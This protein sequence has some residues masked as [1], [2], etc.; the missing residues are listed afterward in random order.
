MIPFA[1]LQQ[2]WDVFLMQFVLILNFRSGR[3]LASS[4]LL[5]PLYLFLLLV[6][7]PHIRLADGTQISLHRR[8]PWTQ[9]SLR[10]SCSISFLVWGPPDGG[11]E[12]TGFLFLCVAPRTPLMSS[13]A[14]SAPIR[15]LLLRPPCCLPPAPST[16][17]MQSGTCGRRDM[18][19]FGRIRPWQRAPG[20]GSMARSGPDPVAIG[21]MERTKGGDVRIQCWNS[22]TFGVLFAGFN[23]SSD[24]HSSPR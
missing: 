17:A 14:L 4:L 6:C 7:R 5:A 1:I 21:M 16:D 22:F 10:S 15:L 8:R 23:S 12:I 13:L 20:R 11:E 9:L 18:A 24:R 3:I 19:R 2:L